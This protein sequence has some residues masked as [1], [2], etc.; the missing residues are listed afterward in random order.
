MTKDISKAKCIMSFGEFIL[1][2]Y[3]MT[4]CRISRELWW[5][6]QEFLDIISP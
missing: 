1:V 3:Y 5:T 4:A 2:C 6:N